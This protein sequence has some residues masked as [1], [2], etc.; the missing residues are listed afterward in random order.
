[1][2]PI[3]LDKNE[4]LYK[5]LEKL[6][7]D[8]F[9]INDRFYQDICSPY[10]TESG[11]DILLS[12]RIEDI[13]NDNYSC[14]LNC[15]YSSYTPNTGFLTC[16]CSI[17][18]EN[19]TLGD[20]GNLVL[21]SFKNVFH[22]INYKFIKCYKLVFHINVITINLGS[23][24]CIALFLCYLVFLILYLIN[25]IK[26][27]KKSVDAFIKKKNKSLSKKVSFNISQNDLE[28]SN[29][30][31]QFKSNKKKLNNSNITQVV[32]NNTPFLSLVKVNKKEKEK[33]KNLDTKSEGIIKKR[34]N[35][36]KKND[37]AI[38]NSDTKSECIPHKKNKHKKEENINK[39]FDIKSEGII[40]KKNRHKN[41]KLND[42]INSKI[43]QSSKRKIKY[44][45]FELNNLNYEEAIKNDKRTLL[46][47]YWSKLK[48]RHLIFF[49]F[50]AKNDFNIIYVKI[51]RFAL[52]I[53]TNIAMNALFFSDQSMHKIYLSYGKYDLVQ[54][55]PQIIYSSLISQIFDFLVL[56]LI[57]T[58]K[59]VFEIINL[60][61]SEKEKNENQI[62]KVFKVIKIKFVIFFSVSFLLFAFFWYFISAFCA[63]YENTQ[64]TFL[65]DFLTS[66]FTG[67]L[68]PFAIYFFFTLLRKLALKDK[69]KKRFKFIYAIG[70]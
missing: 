36:N 13:Y 9:D 4:E 30:S 66:F 68:Y 32:N 50:F 60:E 41:M 2:Y 24:F 31:L 57:V 27:L 21:H 47:M 40:K 58:D 53:C 26:S 37:L 64:V 23:L 48:R 18:N 1:M 52:Q 38:K 7:Y 51:V 61:L 14:P 49:T 54:Q 59:Q 63:V 12:D 28:E 19:I 25:G 10:E 6:G 8:M 43:I 62:G 70:N 65:K 69:E 46:E 11:T 67:L 16:N 20:I 34:K 55:I 56:F 22:S 15:S 29:K 39:N 35:K 5:D 42:T 3:S 17:V 45:E 33:G 44:S